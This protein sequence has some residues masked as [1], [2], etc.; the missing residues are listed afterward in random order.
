MNPSA[1][2]PHREAPSPDNGTHAD[3]LSDTHE[4][5]IL[6]PQ[7]AFSED[8]THRARTAEP[9]ASFPF[10]K[11]ADSDR[12]F[13]A[14]TRIL[15]RGPGNHL[16]LTGERG[17][18][19]STVVAE[20]ARRIASGQIPFLRD[21][22]LLRVDCRYLPPDD[23]RERLAHML[24]LIA[25]HPRLIVCVDGLASLLRSE[26]GSGNKAVLLA[27]LTRSACRLIGL[28]T[29][30]EYEELI[31]DDSDFGEFFTRVDVAEADLDVSL[32]LLGRF[33]EGLQHKYQVGIDD[34]A[35]RQAVVLSSNYILNDHLPAKALKLLHR[36]CEDVHYERSQHGSTRNCVSP[37]DIVRLVAEKTGVPEETLRGIAERSNYEQ[38]LREVVFGQ[39][40]AIHEVATELG[41]I[42][43]GMTDPTK[44]AS[45]LL[46]LGETGV[47]KTELAKVL[48]RFYST[49]GRLKTYTLGNCVEP[50]SVS[51]IIGVPPG[52]VGHDQGGRLVKE[53][54]ADPYGVFLLDEVDKAHPDVLQPF[55]NLFD[56][57]WVADQRGV[58]GYA[59]KSIFILTSNVGQRMI[60]DMVSQGKSKEEISS[61]MKEVLTQIRHSKADRPVFTPEFLARIKRVIVFNSLG[62]PAMLSIAK[63]LVGEMQQTWAT[64]RAKTLQVPAALI[65]HLGEVAHQLNE[66]S[67][68]KEG[69]RIVRKLLSDWIEAPLQ[70]AITEGVGEYRD[71]TDV[72]IAFTPS[73]GRL[74]EGSPPTPSVSVQFIRRQAS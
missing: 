68:G 16:L 46:F 72:V 6:P 14:I 24:A 28:L 47:G 17:A 43:A 69:G 12:L 60:A 59:S 57:G 65:G 53:L 38:S 50:H 21:H 9:S 56:E 44:P 25:G 48:A 67:K 74:A 55:L 23:S 66:Q 11:D 58:R 32:K 33:A 30:R 37:D 34:E 54:Q 3:V 62:R 71:S 29:P 4:A 8:L 51:T 40:H 63:K 61:R 52:Y 18:G 45:V 35:V 22:R 31:A 49:S 26:R 64:Q 70:R 36:A 1:H 73:E 42:K 15:H 27:G 2:A 39:D 5:W 20:L 7:L 10:E 13:D 41:L 19:K